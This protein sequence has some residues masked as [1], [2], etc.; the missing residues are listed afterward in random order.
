MVDATKMAQN[1]VDA[2]GGAKN[3]ESVSRCMTC[4]RFVVR[5][6]ALGN[7]AALKGAGDVVVVVRG[8]GKVQV[9]VGSAVEEVY[10]AVCR[11]LHI[12]PE[13]MQ[14]ADAAAPGGGEGPSGLPEECATQE[15]EPL[16]V[17]VRAALDR[18]LNAV[19]GALSGIIVPILPV[20]IVVGIFKMCAILFAPG[21]LGWLAED[22]D[23]MRLFNFVGDAGYYFLP[24]F[25][26]YSA[27][28][29]FECNVVIAQFIAGVMICPQVLGIVEAGEPF[30]VYGIPMYLVDYTQA[31]IPII[32]VVWAMAHVERFFKR[33]IPHVVRAIAVP[34]LTVAVMLPVALC[35]LG[36]L[37]YV[38]VGWLS[39]GILWLRDTVGI[40]AIIVVALLWPFI[41]M[42]G[43]H[44]PIL[45]SLLPMFTS[46]GYDSIVFPGMIAGIM[47]KMSVYLA[48]ALRAKGAENKGVGWECFTAQA[49]AGVGEP[50]LYGVLLRDRH[51]FVWWACGALAGAVTFYVLGAD[52][53]I[54]TSVGFPFLYPLSFGPDVVLGAI[55]CGVGVL[56][57]FLLSMVFGFDGTE[58]TSPLAKLGEQARRGKQMSSK[59]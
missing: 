50:G 51:A 5:D 14:A 12:E 57:T 49:F 11:C 35:V 59:Q 45:T 33:V 10:A 46:M 38:V 15:P 44:V 6:D 30:T 2:L 34:V 55:G 22:S 3:I 25:T 7:I 23:L 9:V 37:C 21:Y 36:P 39:A 16:L 43:M 18:G 53:Y 28:R 4:L 19:M 13:R 26:S 27:A 48:Y 40:V 1:I 54:F 41:I 20:F 32:L 17:R 47:A 42:F 31:V 56:T 52:V 8:Q 58:H 29:K 24:F